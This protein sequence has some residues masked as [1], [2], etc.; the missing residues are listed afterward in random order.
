[1]TLRMS[2]SAPALTRSASR[3]QAGYVALGAARRGV[4]HV[5]DGQPVA[6]VE[7]ARRAAGRERLARHAGAHAR[8]RVAAVLEDLGDVLDLLGLGDGVRRGL[9]RLVGVQR[10][11]VVGVRARLELTPGHVGVELLQLLTQGG[12]VLEGQLADRLELGLLALQR[13]ALVALDHG[14]DDDRRH[15]EQDEED[16]E[17]HG[18]GYVP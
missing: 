8:H 11:L 10:P 7:E 15:G 13:L 18:P 6:R 16:E 9:G 1:M 4:G 2:G 3:A 5:L 17:L 12:D 14:P